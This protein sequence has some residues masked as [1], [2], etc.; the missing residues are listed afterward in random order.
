[1]SEPNPI[2]AQTI[3]N[4]AQPATVVHHDGRGQDQPITYMHGATE[5]VNVRLVPLTKVAQYFDTIGDIHAFVEFVTDMPK[6]WAE[7]LDDDSL[8]AIDELGKAQNDPRFA[9]LLARQKKT[10]QGVKPMAI[11]SQEVSALTNSLATP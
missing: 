2:A 1:M 6:G 11:S 4:G 7:T 3:I 9:R 8:Y 10:L 5:V